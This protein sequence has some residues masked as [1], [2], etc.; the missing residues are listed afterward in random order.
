M[1]KFPQDASCGSVLKKNTW[2]LLAVGL[3]GQQ[4]DLWV[5]ASAEHFKSALLRGGA[6]R[7]GL[8]TRL[9]PDYILPDICS[10]G[11]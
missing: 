3:R 11:I 8:I 7:E 4:T 9:K 1:Q 5:R 6:E 10:Y 2:M